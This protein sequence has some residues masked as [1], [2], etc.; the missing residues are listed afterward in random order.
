MAETIVTPERPAR[1]RVYRHAVIVRITHWINAACFVFLLLSGL[2]IFNAHPHLYWGDASTF[3]QNNQPTDTFLSFWTSTET[4][5][6]RGYV[7][8]MGG[9]LFDTTGFLA[10]SNYRGETVQR[11]FPTWLT[12]PSRQDL[13]AGRLWHFFFA[14]IFVINGIVYVAYGLAG[15]HFWRDL[16]PTRDQWRTI[17]RTVW[18]HV[19]FRFPRGEEATRYNIL[20]KLAYL[21]AVIALIVMV[22]TGLSMSPGLNAAFPWLPELFGGRQ[23]ARTFHFI[24]ASLLVL[25]AI[26]HIVMV[27]VS[28][29]WNNFRSMITGRYVIKEEKHDVLPPS[30]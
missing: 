18:D 27:L 26:I 23:S 2:Q 16:I 5:E 6:R 8:I 24:S 12:L 4:G 10:A 22:L 25:F 20:Q 19:R 21:V 14:W 28:G 30:P 1:R 3:D 9:K 29:V 11:A 7:Q 17:G 13:A 15:R